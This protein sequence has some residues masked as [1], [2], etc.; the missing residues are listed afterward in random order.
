MTLQYLQM[1][2]GAM[3]AGGVGSVGGNII[4]SEIGNTVDASQQ[5][6]I[7]QQTPIPIPNVSF[8]RQI[9]GSDYRGAI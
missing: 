6:I 2:R 7:N 8:A 4:G 3:T 9:T 5:T 1:E